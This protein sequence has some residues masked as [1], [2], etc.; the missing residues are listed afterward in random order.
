[1]N[2]TLG[3]RCFQPD[4]GWYT[5]P[6]DTSAMSLDAIATSSRTFSAVVLSDKDLG[7]DYTAD[8]AATGLSLCI[9]FESDD[10]GL[11]LLYGVEMY[12]DNM[13]E[14]SSRNVSMKLYNITSKLQSIIPELSKPSDTSMKLDLTPPRR[15]T[16]LATFYSANASSPWY[17]HSTVFSLRNQCSVEFQVFE[18]SLPDL[19][20][21]EPSANAHH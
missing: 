2:N 1:M 8:S 17:V 11:E 9:L 3:I 6:M 18:M 10:N 14:I 7:Y 15:C 13:E 20:K 19:P 12:H 21:C 5:P 16:N 4:I